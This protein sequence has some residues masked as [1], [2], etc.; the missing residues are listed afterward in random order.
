MLKLRRY[1]L[2]IAALVI[3]IG[4]GCEKKTKKTEPEIEE[5]SSQLASIPTPP[6]S[7]ANAVTLAEG[8]SPPSAATQT[9]SIVVS[10]HM[11][12][13]TFGGKTLV[14][15]SGTT[16]LFADQDFKIDPKEKYV[17]RTSVQG[18]DDQGVG[19]N[20]NV[21]Q[22]VG[23]R[24]FKSDGREIFSQD[25][26][27]QAGATDTRLTRPLA[28]GDTEVHVEDASGWYNGNVYYLRWLAFFTQPETEFKLASGVFTNGSAGAWAQGGINNNIITLSAPWPVS[29]PTLP[30]GT[31]V[32]NAISNGTWTYIDYNATTVDK[33][34]VEI[35]M[36]GYNSPEIRES[37][38]RYGTETIRPL[39]LPNYSG[40]AS[41]R[42][43]FGAFTVS[44]SDSVH[45]SGEYIY[46]LANE[47]P[48][49][50]RTEENI[51][52]EVVAENLVRFVAP[53]VIDA[54][55]FGIYVAPASQNSAEKLIEVIVQ[56]PQSTTNVL[57]KKLDEL[58][59]AVENLQQNQNDNLKNIAAINQSLLEQIRSDLAN[60]STQNSTD[61]AELL[62]AV[63]RLTERDV[64]N[65]ELLQILRDIRDGVSYPLV[66]PYSCDATNDLDYYGNYRDAFINREQC[67]AAVADVSIHG[68]YCDNDQ[69]NNRDGATVRSFS[70][71][72]ACRDFVATAPRIPRPSSYSC[73]F[74]SLYYGATSIRFFSTSAACDEA[75]IQANRYY[76]YFCDGRF[77]F[78]AFETS[79]SATFATKEECQASLTDIFD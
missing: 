73:Y 15:A 57:A 32:R 69:M 49:V 25:V 79:S 45:Y 40:K 19:V 50:W 6:E 51:A 3:A 77:R 52:L 22:Y 1:G 4:T 16:Y 10:S 27:K 46:L 30:A 39:Y 54:E 21:R 65:R 14:T 17:F 44:R 72:Q 38:F 13:A 35:T 60:A 31:A 36:G 66:T 18:G 76:G 2:V 29:Y 12:V 5:A 75:Q 43:R 48:V 64:D 74:S 26:F 78:S 63:E 56:N 42:A 61:L 62:A 9:N 20:T 58:K 53:S 34:Q 71:W 47:G 67:L 24:S 37:G 11:Y 28:P 55:K 7:S 68:L 33:R 8:E 70:S 41:D 59:T 23:W